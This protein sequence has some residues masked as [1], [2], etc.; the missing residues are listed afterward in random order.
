[1]EKIIFAGGIHGVG[2]STLCRDIAERIGLIHLSASELLKWKDLNTNDEKNKKVT[3]IPDTQDRLLKGLVAAIEQNGKYILDGHFCLFNKNGD[4]TPVPFDTFAGINP[5]ALL[6]VTGDPNHIASMLKERDQRFY[7]ADLLA[8]MQ[9]QELIHAQMIANQLAI[10][11]FVFNIKETNIE[12][13]IHE[14]N[15]SFT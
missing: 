13:L 2:K 11:L 1:M 15:E 14:L 6:L 12:Q 3:D 10:R 7:A 4:V 9:E 5:I 8:E